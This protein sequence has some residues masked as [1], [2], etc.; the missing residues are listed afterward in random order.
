MAV[1]K[2]AIAGGGGG[3]GRGGGGCNNFRVWN[4]QSY[5]AAD[6][7]LS[8]PI[9]LLN[10]LYSSRLSRGLRD[11][12][13]T[14]AAAAQDKE[15]GLGRLQGLATTATRTATTEETPPVRERSRVYSLFT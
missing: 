11:T 14:A 3:G 6:H 12:K 9:L 5:N 13:D 8:L 10:F 7:L 2:Y 15:A 4:R 1:E